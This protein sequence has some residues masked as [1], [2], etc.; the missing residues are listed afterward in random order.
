MKSFQDARY[1]SCLRSYKKLRTNA[2][3]TNNYFIKL[4]IRIGI[5]HTWL[6]K[7]LLILRDPSYN[8]T[9][10]IYSSYMLCYMLHT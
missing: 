7:G 5:T 1:K 3:I 10:I 9:I 4:I 8:F 6:L 2:V